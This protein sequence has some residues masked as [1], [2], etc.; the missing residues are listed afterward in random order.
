MYNQMLIKTT[1]GDRIDL[2]HYKNY[3]IVNFSFEIFNEDCSEYD[4]SR[5]SQILFKLFAKQNGKTLATI[6]MN[7]DSPATNIIYLYDV[8]QIVSQRSP[9]IMWH[10]CYSVEGGVNKLLFSGVS[11]I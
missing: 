1:T 4:F 9:R 5:S 7:T 6:S 8:N 11:E 10:E 3:A 2:L